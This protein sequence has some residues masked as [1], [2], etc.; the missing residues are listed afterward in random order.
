M[1]CPQCGINRGYVPSRR[2]GACNDCAGQPGI[3]A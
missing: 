2:L 1:T 3:A